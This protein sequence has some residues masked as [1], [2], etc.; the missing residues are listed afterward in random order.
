MRREDCIRVLTMLPLME[1]VEGLWDCSLYSYPGMIYGE[2]KCYTPNGGMEWIIPF[3]FAYEAEPVSEQ[4]KK[5]LDTYSIDED[6]AEWLN[7]KLENKYS[8]IYSSIPSVRELVEDAEWK[9]NEL[10]YL[11]TRAKIIESDIIDETITEVNALANS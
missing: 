2:L 5:Y 10:M 1:S 7:A 9:S 11:Y 6:V 4:L 8:S 3:S